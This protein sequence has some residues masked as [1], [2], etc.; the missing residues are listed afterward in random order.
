MPPSEGEDDS[1]KNTQHAV[2]P[3]SA[4]VAPVPAAPEPAKAEPMKAEPSKPAPGK[5]EALRPEA[6]KPEAAKADAPKPAEPSPAPAAAATPTE[7][8]APEP[9]PASIAA[10]AHAPEGKVIGQDNADSRIQ[11][12][13]SGDDCWLQVRELDGQ[14]LMSRLLRR[15]DSYMVPNRPGLTLMV[16][17]AGALDVTV[18]GKRAPA[19]GNTGQ[20]RRD[21]K[22][23]P[24]KLLGGG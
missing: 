11:L 22:L 1:A 20:V 7:T 13:A 23:D 18:D 19:L 3:A 15:G 17:N 2:A 9:T 24:D 14:L 10:P 4:P 6:P 16:G 8:K 12:K 5:P 21:I